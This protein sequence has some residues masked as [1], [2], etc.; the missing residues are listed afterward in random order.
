MRYFLIILSLLLFTNTC[1]A[2]PYR[3]DAKTK[4]I[5]AGTNFSLRIIEPVNTFSAQEGDYFSGVIENEHI[6][7]T[8]VVIPAGSVVRGS[9]NKLKT[10][11]RFSRGAVLYLDFDHLVTP[12]GRQLPLSMSVVGFD[13]IGY[14]G[15]LFKNQGYGEALKQDWNK[16]KSYTIRSVNYG[17]RVKESSPGMQYITVP[18]CAVGGAVATG[19]YMV[20]KVFAD[21]WT[22][23]Q[24]VSLKQGDVINVM[25]TQPIDVPVN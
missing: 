23:G 24:E 8:S 22:K 2:G 9:V 25:L 17:L 19:G 1:F 14:D 16:A 12:N 21:M 4:R 20:G 13:Y 5:P 15:G 6:T 3:A 7:G 10:S 18:F 11:K